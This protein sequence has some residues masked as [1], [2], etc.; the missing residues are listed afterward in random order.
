MVYKAD[1]CWYIEGWAIIDF[2]QILKEGKK[3][4]ENWI[5]NL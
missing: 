4:L 3:K 1:R 2:F 5:K